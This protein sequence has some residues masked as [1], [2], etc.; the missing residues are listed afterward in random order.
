MDSRDVDVC[1]QIGQLLYDAAPVRSRSIIMRAQ[2]ADDEDQAKFEFD[3]VAE[4]GESSWFLGSAS[5]NGKLLELLLEHRRFFLSRNQPKWKL[6]TI[7]ID[8]EKRRFSLDLKY[9]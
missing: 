3:A 4:N 7:I 6:F 5:L 8:V 1:R 2:L 9:D